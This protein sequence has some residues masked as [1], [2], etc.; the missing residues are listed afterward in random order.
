M[1]SLLDTISYNL[2]FLNRKL[3]IFHLHL[4]GKSTKHSSLFCHFE[5]TNRC[6]KI[7]CRKTV[8]AKNQNIYSIPWHKKKKQR[9]IVLSSSF[10]V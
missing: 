7:R 1:H 4:T 6:Q 8:T 10:L 9:T 3:Y 5:Q 2:E